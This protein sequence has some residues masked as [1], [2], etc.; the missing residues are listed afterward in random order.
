[1]DDSGKYGSF[2]MTADELTHFCSMEADQAVLTSLRKNG[3]P[4]GIPLGF[5]YGGDCFYITTTKDRSL[6][7]RL[8]NDARV[9]LTIPSRVAYPTK[10]VIAEGTAASV[11]DPDDAIS[12]RILFDGPADKFEK[13]RVDPERFFQ[14]WVAIGRVVYRIDVTNLVTFDGTKTPK[15]EKYGTGQRMP[16]D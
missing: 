4:F 1:L 9:C 8:R 16:G 10:F 12:R 11:D 14:S 5:I 3:A 13:M 6:P 7:K 15:G 2:A